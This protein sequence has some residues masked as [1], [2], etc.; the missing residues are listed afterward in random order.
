MA[1]SFNNP[2][3]GPSTYGTRRGRLAARALATTASAAALLSVAAVS[4]SAAP[5]DVSVADNVVANVNVSSTITL[6]LDQQGFDLN[7]LPSTRVSQTGAVTGRVTTNNATGYSVGVVAEA[8]AL[9]AATNGNLDT[10]PI[11]NLA[12]V[13]SD[14]A[15]APLSNDEAAPVIT[16]TKATR[17]ALAGDTFSDDYR[18]DIPDVNSDTYSVTLDY[19]AT[20]LA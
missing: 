5:G 1:A 8:A 14:G 3:S 4:A 19:T 18:V 12:V 20:A 9:T 16:T 15:Y 6:N 10:I 7:G 11:E 2:F 13:D 17:S